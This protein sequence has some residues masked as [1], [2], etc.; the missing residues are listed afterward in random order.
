M[1]TGATRNTGSRP[2]WSSKVVSPENHQHDLDVKR[3]EYPRAGISEY[4]SVNPQ[5][6]L[7]TVLTLKEGKYILHG[8]FGPGTVAR[9]RVLPG[10][11]VAVEEVWAAA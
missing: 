5:T 3:Q 1:P 11:E 4:R 10:F 8:Q 7:V 2:A 9:F 6:Q